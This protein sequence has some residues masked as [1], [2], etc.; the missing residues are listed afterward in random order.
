MNLVGEYVPADNWQPKYV[1]ADT[2]QPSQG[3]L[4]YQGK[5]NS[6]GNGKRRHQRKRG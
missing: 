2:I 6:D 4:G 3:D 1:P 5:G